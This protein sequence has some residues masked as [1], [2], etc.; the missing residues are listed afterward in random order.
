MRIADGGGTAPLKLKA[1]TGTAPLQAPKLDAPRPQRNVNAERVGTGR[2]LELGHLPWEGGARGLTPRGLQQKAAQRPGLF[3]RISN[4]LHLG[5]ISWNKVGH[6]VALAI[7]LT[8]TTTGGFKAVKNALSAQKKLDDI[9]RAVRG[10]GASKLTARLGKVSSGI[11]VLGGI[12]AATKLKG[13]IG[14]LRHGVT[15]GKA[16]KLAGDM[17]TTVRG[18][19]EAVKLVK[20]AGFIGKRI[21]PGLSVAADA[22]DAINRV[23][24]LSHWNKL[25]TKDKIANTAY[26]AGD[27]ADAV[28]TVF[29]PAKVVGAGLTLVAMGAENFPAIKHGAGVAVHAVEHVASSAEHEA[30]HIAHKAVDKVK[31]FFHGL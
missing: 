4:A 18:A 6:G 5:N 20:G 22:S 24:N 31:H 3:G 29:P 1:A 12:N 25:S 13:D 28:G 11:R 10:G 19:D 7:P 23:Q 27:V 14:D 16:N 30:S 8:I 9:R 26:L 21:A 17:L 15:L 2:H